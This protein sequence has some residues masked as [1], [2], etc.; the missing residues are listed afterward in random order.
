MKVAPAIYFGPAETN[1]ASGGSPGATCAICGRSTYPKLKFEPFCIRPC[2]P[3]APMKV[4]LQLRPS[5]LH[6]TSIMP[7][8][9]GVTP[10][11]RPY[12]RCQPEQIITQ[13]PDSHSAHIFSVICDERKI[14]EHWNTHFA[15]SSWGPS[16]NRRYR[17]DGKRAQE[18]KVKSTYT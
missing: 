10:G 16:T 13:R 2:G 14:L 12:A 9:L 11:I 6:L 1:R 7:V 4:S 5:T 18:E 15:Q 3:N 17:C 8:R